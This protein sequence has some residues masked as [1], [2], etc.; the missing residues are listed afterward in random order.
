MGAIASVLS[1][2]RF[3]FPQPN[4]RPTKPDAGK[5]KISQFKQLAYQRKFREPDDFPISQPPVDFPE[6]LNAD[7]VGS[8]WKPAVDFLHQFL[9]WS[10]RWIEFGRRNIGQNQSV[11]P[12]LSANHFDFATADWTIAVEKD[13]ET[14]SRSGLYGLLREAKMHYDDD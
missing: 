11:L 2:S 13:L 3:A 14:S 4:H 10:V 5:R 9:Q 7:Q 6:D 8:V 12:V 1:L